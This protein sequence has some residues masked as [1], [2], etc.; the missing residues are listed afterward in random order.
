M[1]S[2]LAD[3]ETSI[4]TIMSKMAAD[5]NAINLSQGYPGFDISPELVELVHFYMKKGYNQYAPMPGLPQLRQRISDKV[6]RTHGWHTN[7]DDHITVTSGA[8][9]AIFA[10]ITAL[11]HSNDE[12]IYFEP[13]YDS[14]HPAILLNKG[15]PIPIQLSFPDFSIPW[16]EVEK[17]I[18]NKTKMVII[19]TPQNPSGAIL[20]KN[21]VDRL[22]ELIKNKDIFVLSD[23][24]YEHIIFDNSRHHSVLS[25]EILREKS[26]A[27]FSFGKTFHA[28]GWKMG[29]SVASKKI[30]N[31]IKKIHQFLV[32]SVNT[33]IQFA[34]T[35]YLQNPDHYYS[36][37]SFFQSKRDLFLA[38]MK[39]SRF[40]PLKSSGTYFQ[41]FSY[42][43]ISNEP[44]VLV[45]EKF[46]KEYGVA[47]IP[48]SV[49]YQDR[50][51][52]RLLRF[53]FAKDEDSLIEAA[54][55]LC[56]I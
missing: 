35:D 5:Y 50:T 19:N 11:V 49:F 51:D 7:A 39:K 17:K 46:T 16:E 4:F 8:T 55:I 21:D 45:A 40:K 44:D 48:F 42:R 3:T 28:T 37:P 32:F 18:T 1:R 26:I 53:C 12:V 14:Y 6:S 30:T 52:N 13:A 20:S 31:E 34:M 25:N 15:I 2:K 41:T 29:Y 27:V 10:T 9:E 56:K 38:L 43:A 33:P 23:E 47:S 36:L 22:A 24:V 54:E